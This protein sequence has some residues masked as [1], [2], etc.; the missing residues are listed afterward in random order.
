MRIIF[1]DWV[2]ALDK[3]RLP[4]QYDDGEPLEVVNAPDGWAWTLNAQMGGNLDVIPLSDTDGVVGTTLSKSQLALAGDYRLQLVGTKDGVT[5]HTNIIGMAV[6]VSLSGDATWPTLPTAFSDALD[7][8]EDAAD[9]AESAATHGPRISGTN[10]WEVWDP[11]K[12]EYVDT[13][14]DASGKAPA[15]VDGVTPDIKIGTVTT[16]EPGQDATASIGGTAAEPLLNLGIPKGAKGDKGDDGGG[17]SLFVAKF[18]SSGVGANR[19]W[20]CDKTLSEIL[21]AMR[22]DTPVIGLVD[23]DQIATA[24]RAGAGVEFTAIDENGSI[25]GVFVDTGIGGNDIIS[26]IGQSCITYSLDDR[27]PDSVFATD[28]IGAVVFTPKSDFTSLGLTSATVGQT[29]KVKQVDDSG[30]PTEWEAVDQPGAIEKTW[31]KIIDVDISEATASITRDGLDNCTKFFARYY[32]VKNATSTP[33][34]LDIH[35]N[36]EM[37]VA[38]AVPTQAEGD[39]K[40]AYGYM[41]FWYN[42]LVW[43]FTRSAG[44]IYNGNVN[45]ASNALIPYNTVDNV[46]E[47]KKIVFSVPNSIYAPTSGKLEVWAR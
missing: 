34:K 6:P 43:L 38:N 12:G 39:T 5:R 7:R 23:G 37:V 42:G 4:R 33:S 41:T 19:T 32:N 13:M 17:S 28:E 45:A 9:R 26:E 24:K 30:R 44:A 2:I 27:K 3:G 10:T 1:S 40:E 21:S 14:V 36:G 35:I 16:L 46:G 18:T 20:S 29:I 11:D 25:W 15:G 47:A 31:T 8:A 22:G